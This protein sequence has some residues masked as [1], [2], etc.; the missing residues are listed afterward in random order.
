MRSIRRAHRI[1]RAL[2][3]SV[4]GLTM[5]ELSAELDI[6]PST[7]HR[8]VAVLQEHQFVSRQDSSARCCLGPAS[9]QAGLAARRPRVTSSPRAAEVVAGLADASGQG[10]LLVELRGRR[11]EA[12]LQR[13][14]GEW[15]GG[16]AG[17][18]MPFHAVAA[19]RTLLLDMDDTHVMRLLS[20]YQFLPRRDRTP[21]TVVELQQRLDTMRG[22]GHES[23]YGEYV[24]AV[25]EFAAPVRGGAGQVLAGLAVVVHEVRTTGEQAVRMGERV[26]HAAM[27]ISTEFGYRV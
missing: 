3:N 26:A 27:E 15:A 1:L 21:G 10:A 17:D 14:L 13:G 2:A 18:L 16:Y 4:D 9:L 22:R 20:E 12:V 23:V 7:V 6:P 5:T 25:W 8:L 11:A 24:P 19:A